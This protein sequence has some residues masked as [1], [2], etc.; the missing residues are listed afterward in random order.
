MAVE[1]VAMVDGAVVK[2]NNSVILSVLYILQGR[3]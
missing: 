3:S 1:E 2:Q